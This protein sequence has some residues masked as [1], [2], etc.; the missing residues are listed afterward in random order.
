MKKTEPKKILTG[1]ILFVALVAGVFSAAAPAQQKLP[2]NRVQGDGQISPYNGRE[3]RLE[4]IVTARLRTGFFI[5]TPDG[6]TDDDPRTSEGIYVYTRGD[7]MAAAAVGNLVSVTGTVT[8]FRPRSEPA[9]LPLTEL[10]LRSPGGRDQS[11]A[12]VRVRVVSKDNPLPAPVALTAADFAANDPEALEKYEGMRVLIP[13]MTVVGPTR[14]RFDPNRGEAV[15]QGVFYGVLKGFGRPFREP[16]MDVSR[17]AAAAEK[18]KWRKKHP[19]IPLFDANPEVIRVD[20]RAQ[21][22]SPTIDVTAQAVIKNLSGVLH[23]AFHRYTVLTDVK[24]DATVGNFIKSVGLPAPGD[25]QFSVAGMNLENFFDEEDD[26]AVKEDIVSPEAFEIKMRK[27]SLAVRDYL[28]LPD[29]IGVSEAENL[30]ILERLA[31]R[32]G[33]DA[34]AAGRPD[35]KYRAYLIEGRDGRGIDVGF[36]VK[37]ARVKVVGTEQIG[38]DIEFTTPQGKK[39]PLNDRPSLMLRAEIS[40]P[41]RKTPFALTA[42]VSHLKSFRGYD[43]PKDGERVRLKKKLQAEFL[44][45]FVQQRQT[46]DPEEKIVLLGD[47]NFY[48]FGDGVADIIGTI[49]GVPAGRDSVLLVSEDLVEPDL[50]NLVDLIG[51]EQKYSYIYDGSAQ[52]LDHMLVNQALFKHAVGFGFARLNADFPEIYRNNSSRPERFSDHDVAVGYFSLD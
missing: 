51:A 25:R 43:D 6:Q 9:S 50:I 48:Q 37:T 33:A 11:P 18:E 22:G 36:L 14:G 38:R 42:I 40:D 13:E 16:G 8:E 3:V 39:E 52:V 10:T 31:A 26:P 2:I 5:Q 32:I 20:S 29:L 30:E 21:P 45:R 24:T 15:S 34:A 4:G 41:R 35:P 17:F 27:I 12:A 19:Q 23:Y 46:R 49:R 47:F 44:A 7:P 1:I 28:H